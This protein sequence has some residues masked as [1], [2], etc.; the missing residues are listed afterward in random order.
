[1]IVISYEDA[2]VEHETN[3]SGV[4]VNKGLVVDLCVTSINGSI[5]FHCVHAEPVILVSLIDQRVSIRR[6]AR[7]FLVDLKLRYLT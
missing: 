3:S 6:R 5:A 1:M 2:E 4:V 7:Q